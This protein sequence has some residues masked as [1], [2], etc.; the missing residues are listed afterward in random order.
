M[1]SSI[2]ERA[3]LTL[4]GAITAGVLAG[5]LV[6]AIAEQ[7]QAEGHGV[8]IPAGDKT[9]Y[10]DPAVQLASGNIVVAGSGSDAVESYDPLTWTWSRGPNLLRAPDGS[11]HGEG[12]HRG[13]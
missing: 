6:P 2:K 4:I 9:T 7:G 3:R 11:E 8:W 13:F 12:P 5:A 10:G 1:S